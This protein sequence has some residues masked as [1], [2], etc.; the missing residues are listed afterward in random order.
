[1]KW[2]G[3]KLAG[4]AKSVPL[5]TAA[6][7]ALGISGVFSPSAGA[8]TA[9]DVR[10][11]LVINSSKYKKIEPVVTLTS[12]GGFQISVGSGDKAPLPWKSEA[13]GTIRVS[14]DGYSALMLETADFAAAKALYTKLAAL[15]E[16]SFVLARTKLGKPSFQVFYGSVATQA[17]AE[18]AAAAALKDAGVAA[19]LK[20]AQ[21]Q[22]TGP[23]H[24]AA[25]TYASEAAAQAQAAVYT[26]AGV[27][28]DA[29]LVQDAAGKA[30]FQVWVGGEATA[31]ALETVKQAALK[32]V[33]NIPLQA[34]G[35][36]AAPYLIQRADVSGASS[37]AAA[38]P[39][40][41]AS[42]G[43]QKT[44][45][46]AGTQTI[47]VKERENRSYRGGMEISSYQGRLALVNELPMDQYL[48]SVVGSELNSE[49]P[50]EALKA[51]A[52]AART[53]ALKQANKYEIAQVTDTTLDQAYYGTAKEFAAGRQAV[54][55][56]THEV[57]KDKSG[58][59]SPVFS[60]NAGG[61]TADP[62]EVWGN[63][64]AYLQSVASPDEGAEKGKAVWYRV[65]LTSGVEG[66]VHSM[67]LKDSGTKDSKGAPIYTSTEQD[68]NVR[69]APY[70][71][72]AGNPAI[73]QLALK[74]KVVVLGQA[75]E[76][77]AYSWIRGPYTPED[78]K[79]M[80]AAGGVTVNG[81]VTSLQVTKRGPSGRATEL[82]VNGTP[83]KVAYPDAFR[84][85]L[86]G[87]PSTLFEIEQ[88]GSYTGGT[89][90]TTSSAV[91]LATSAGHVTSAAASA[92]LYVLSAGQQAPTAQKAA[93]L[94]ALTAAGVSQL[95]L[96]GNTT[97]PPA[98]STGAGLTFTFRGN[99]FGHGLG[100]SQWGAK[101]FAEQGYDYKKILQTYYTGVNITKE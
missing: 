100:M 62:S 85:L 8:A 18:A 39:H 27:D 45:V 93:S 32:A 26:G 36:A 5:L 97:A 48:Y 16:D 88:P 15:P 69:S 11:A 12:S 70:V 84:S 96:S 43:A 40:Y 6:A 42:A 9:D 30:A 77:N 55:A 22:F 87:L 60:S 33:P 24:L 59:I 31:A 28:A 98:A 67:Y 44:L 83:V 56:T 54:D 86:G 71:D 61:K 47:T 46:T 41:V 89:G 72:N 92:D 4:G 79:R 38:V 80:L 2:N 21:P 101:G 95:S 37:A 17:A 99:G 58:L 50:L 3:I 7:L 14:L 19:L 35:A 29:V 20:S 73:A 52:V 51:Q 74:E 10:V 75:K 25:G 57:L 76:S 82:A 94:A 81:T 1:M 64:A 23:L 78:I 63:P 66:Y 91:T 34:V 49:W 68:V 90:T 13:A 53:F 65:R